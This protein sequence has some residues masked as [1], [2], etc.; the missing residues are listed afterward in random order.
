MP[1]VAFPIQ[2][3]VIRPGI[4]FLFLAIPGNVKG[5]IRFMPTGITFHSNETT[6]HQPPPS[7]FL[8]ARIT[9]GNITEICLDREKQ[10]VRLGHVALA[11]GIRRTNIYEFL[12][13]AE[14]HEAF[15][16][17]LQCYAPG[18][19][20]EVSFKSLNYRWACL[21]VGLFLLLDICYLGNYFW[22]WF[23]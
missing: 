6:L 8:Q 19:V 3:L 16:E 12:L 23:F 7:E 9:W 5:F 4:K 17:A 20:R 22:H 21:N 11:L 10:Q 18:R 1:Y 14:Q 15:L 2:R 13:N